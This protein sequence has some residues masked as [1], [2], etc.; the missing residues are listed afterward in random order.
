[1]GGSTTN[2][3]SVELLN[4]FFHAELQENLLKLKNEVAVEEEVPGGVGFF[5]A[6]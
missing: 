4:V 1:M 5:V 2:W 3:K 6:S